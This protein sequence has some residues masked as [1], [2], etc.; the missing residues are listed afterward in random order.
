MSREAALGQIDS[1]APIRRR[2]LSVRLL[3]L[4]GWGLAAIGYFGP[5]I[6]HET[7]ALTLSGVDMGEFVKF[8]P[9]VLDGSLTVIRQL[10][11]LP[12]FVVVVSVA[13]LVGSDRLGFPWSVRGFVLVLAVPVS[14]QM[15]PPAW[16]VSSLL[17]PE[18]RGQALALGISWL[19]LAS[20]S[21]WG[22]LP[23]RITAL[24][25]AGL[26]LAAF[27]FSAWQLSVVK[28][29]IDQVYNSPQSLGWGFI[30]CVTGLVSCAA[31]SVLLAVQ[32]PRPNPAPWASE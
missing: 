23:V 7:A 24:L 22:R 17:T 11:Y 25:S 28:P 31:G 21:L 20:F 5:W 16:S 18:F 15:L 4:F 10:F 14:L 27:G 8:L 30:V 19:L 29:A 32:S 6:A 13:L 1:S 12:P 9:G 26:C 2:L 3:L